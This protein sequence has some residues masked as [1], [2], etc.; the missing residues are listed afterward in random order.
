MCHN[1]RGKWEPMTPVL[2]GLARIVVVVEV[3]VVVVVVI[4]VVI[5]VVVVVVI[6]GVVIVVVV[7]MARTTRYVFAK[8]ATAWRRLSVRLCDDC[9]E[10][11]V[12]TK[13]V[14]K[15]AMSVETQA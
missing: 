7:G 10:A 9:W 15:K 11:A 3:V 4:V 8:A 14:K 1:L 12:Q 5:I 2:R 6:V 13:Q